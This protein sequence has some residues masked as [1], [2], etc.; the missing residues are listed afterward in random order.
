MTYSVWDHKHRVYRYYE[1]PER[2]EEAHAPRPAH[3]R[4]T[5]LGLAPEQ[6]AW[7]L[8][9]NARL[10][11]SGERP[12]GQIASKQGG[13]ALGILPVDLTV[14]NLVVLGALGFAAYHYLWRQK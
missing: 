10:V 8:P 11:G 5:Q 3:L 9:S 1:T 13:A 4:P 6:A 7:P 2:S 14:P 12:C